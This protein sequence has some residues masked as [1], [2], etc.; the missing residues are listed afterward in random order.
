MKESYLWNQIQ[1][2]G[3]ALNM[4]VGLRIDN[5]DVTQLPNVQNL[6]LKKYSHNLI[7]LPF[8]TI[9]AEEDMVDRVFPDV[10]MIILKS[11]VNVC[12]FK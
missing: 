3:L 12:L 6:I 11:Y 2:V 10:H 9:Q 7:Q 1:K 4:Q 5:S 8:L